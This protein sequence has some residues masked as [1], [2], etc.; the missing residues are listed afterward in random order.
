MSTEDGQKLAQ[1]Q[2]LLFMET[3]ALEG[4]KVEEAFN[5]ILNGVPLSYIFKIQ[6]LV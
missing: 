2:S 1:E 4:E 6:N 3:S 5:V